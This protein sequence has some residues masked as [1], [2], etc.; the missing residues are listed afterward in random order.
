MFKI[1]ESPVSCWV[2]NAECWFGIFWY[3]IYGWINL[4]IYRFSCF[5]V[6][7][8][9]RY[10]NFNRSL[11]MCFEATSKRCSRKYKLFN[12]RQKLRWSLQDLLVKSHFK[13]PIGCKIIVTV[14]LT[15][16]RK[17]LNENFILLKIYFDSNFVEILN[18]LSN[19][20]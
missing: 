4:M 19:V 8:Y 6:C 1:A 20:S 11:L 13:S 3:N 16:W 17:R 9:F 15:D 18:K 5:S 2:W 10:E 14:V 12:W 7:F